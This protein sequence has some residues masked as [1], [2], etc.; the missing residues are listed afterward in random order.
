MALSSNP[1]V[2]F[3]LVLYNAIQV[4][5]WSAILIALAK[6]FAE[7]KPYETAWD[8]VGHLLIIFQNAAVLEVV[9]A[10]VGA[11]RSPVGTTFIQV[12]SRVALTAVAQ[13]I[14]VARSS[15]FFSLMVG[16]WSLTEVVR[17]LYYVVSQVGEV[18]SVLLWLRYSLFLVLYPS[19]VAGEVGT[20]YSSLPYF[21]AHRPFSLFMPNKYNFAFDSY[22]A[23]WFVL[24]TYL[25][26]LPFMYTYMQGQRRKYLGGKPTDAAGTRTRTAAAASPVQ[27]RPKK[28]D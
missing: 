16:S 9:H 27:R 21:E 15:V 7:G 12:L 22:W 24:A 20:L 19:G 5:G 6:H 18:P 8:S 1:V 3:W 13:H 25:P 23:V 11:V 2:K 17:Y 10:A 14:D 26:G 4:L 28:A